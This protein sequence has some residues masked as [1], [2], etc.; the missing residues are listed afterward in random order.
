M[1]QTIL[2]A[3]LIALAGRLV[4]QADDTLIYCQY[5]TEGFLT[6][7]AIADVSEPNKPDV[8]HTSDDDQ[9][10]FVYTCDDCAIS[11]RVEGR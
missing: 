3:A 11:I 6:Y 10:F 1:K 9:Y 7:E 4:A 8:L 2:S 5:D